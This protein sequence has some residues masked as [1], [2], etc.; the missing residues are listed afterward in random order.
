MYNRW[1]KI[2][3]ESPI[4]SPIVKAHSDETIEKYISQRRKVA[5]KE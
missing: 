4:T 3:N 5:K 1:K 2:S